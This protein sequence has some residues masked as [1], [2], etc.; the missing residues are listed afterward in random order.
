MERTIGDEESNHSARIL[1]VTTGPELPPATTKTL[2]HFI[3]FLTIPMI[4]ANRGHGGRESSKHQK[5]HEIHKTYPVL[6]FT[7]SIFPLGT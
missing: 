3:S 2:N 5:I 6:T 7:A 1:K 4:Q